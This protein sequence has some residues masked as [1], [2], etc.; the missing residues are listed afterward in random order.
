LVGIAS[1]ESRLHRFV[2][3][4]DNS[5]KR[6]TLEELVKSDAHWLKGIN[7]VINDS[8][9]HLLLDG[10]SE[11]LGGKL[12]KNIVLG[13]S[14]GDSKSVDAAFNLKKSEEVRL[15]HAALELPNDLDR[16]TSSL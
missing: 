12:V 9:G 13:I 2:G 3:L 16:D 1:E 10:A 14:D 11:E 7:D 6:L 5:G 15:V 4:A 8:V